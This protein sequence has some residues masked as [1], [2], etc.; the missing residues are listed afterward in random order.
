MRAGVSTMCPLTTT[1]RGALPAIRRTMTSLSPTVKFDFEGL[2]PQFKKASRP[3]PRQDRGRA[4]RTRSLPSTMT[5]QKIV[6]D[7]GEQRADQ[8]RD[9]G[10]ESARF[11][12]IDG[13]DRRQGGEQRDGAGR[14]TEPPRSAR[15]WSSAFAR[16]DAPRH[17]YATVAHVYSESQVLISASA[18]PVG[19]ALALASRTDRILRMAS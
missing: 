14:K 16:A 18:S 7:A 11:R 9:E 17:G 1:T 12:A 2:A 6:G 10:R 5:L 8:E 13:R 15:S 4:V 3:C 19:E